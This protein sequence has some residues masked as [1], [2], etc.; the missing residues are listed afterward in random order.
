MHSL[1][2]W[3]ILQ[4]QYKNDHIHHNQYT[5]QKTYILAH[6]TSDS[7]KRILCAAHSTS[8]KIKSVS[9]DAVTWTSNTTSNLSNEAYCTRRGQTATEHSIW[10]ASP[11]TAIPFFILVYIMIYTLPY[12]MLSIRLHQDNT[13]TVPL[14]PF[15]T[16]TEQRLLALPTE[17]STSHFP[18]PLLAIVPNSESNPLRS[19]SIH[20]AL[21]LLSS[22][23]SS[24]S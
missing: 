22:T 5:L 23:H 6:N 17:P 9:K 2:I 15:D 1:T 10:K 8:H 24:I 12:C 18:L 3:A 16:P 4:K 19:S 7:T 13:S 20:R 21:P 14:S 11:L